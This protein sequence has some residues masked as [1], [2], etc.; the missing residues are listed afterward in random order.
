MAS[1]NY[2]KILIGGS[3][4]LCI[5]V[6]LGLFLFMKK[7]QEKSE[8]KSQ[9]KSQEKPKEK[10]E[11]VPA[12][13]LP[14]DGKKF[15]IRSL[16]G[17][18]LTNIENKLTDDIASAGVFTYNSKTNSTNEG[19][20]NN[21]L[22]TQDLFIYLTINFSGTNAL[23]GAANKVCNNGNVEFAI[24]FKEDWF[25]SSIQCD[26]DA[27]LASNLVSVYGAQFYYV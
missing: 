25:W 9:E 27:V 16:N 4:V 24:L 15:V 18:Y 23:V 6:V 1:S 10:P 22:K 8:E 7:S 3:I 19:F 2:Q 13:Q 21:L 26:V 17:K 12:G 14:I 11:L 20:K 5:G